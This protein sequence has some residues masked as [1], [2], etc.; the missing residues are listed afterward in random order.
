MSHPV[1][2]AAVPAARLELRP[3]LPEHAPEMAEVLSDPALH[4]FTGGAPLDPAALRARYERLTAGSPDPDVAWCNWVLHAS[5][6]RC[7]VGTVQATVSGPAADL[8]AEVAWVV[9]VPWQG[10]GYATEAARALV[11]WLTARGVAR[12]VAHIHP[13]HRASEGVARAAGLAPTGHRQDGEVRWRAV[14]A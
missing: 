7:L 1:R 8:T 11:G 12:V 10:R 13:R 3:L 2:A 5:A 6:E 4:T 14:V 9:G